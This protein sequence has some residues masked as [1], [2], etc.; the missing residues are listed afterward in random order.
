MDGRRG[1]TPE[2][3]LAR[4]Q[5]A[6][7]LVRQQGLTAHEALRQVYQGTPV[8]NVMPTDDPAELERQANAIIEKY[9]GV[10]I[11]GGKRHG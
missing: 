7:G 1:E 2:Q 8:A 6:L 9:A 4:L 10:R 5:R 3:H 11:D